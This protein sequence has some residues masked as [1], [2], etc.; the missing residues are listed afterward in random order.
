MDNKE[1]ISNKTALL[2]FVLIVLTLLLAIFL[3]WPKVKDLKQINTQVGALQGEKTALDSKIKAL[4]EAQS[5]IAAAKPSID[6]LNIAVPNNPAMPEILVSLES[7]VGRTGLVLNQLSPASTGEGVSSGEAKVTISVSGS[8]P[9][10]IRLLETFEKNIRPIKVNSLALTSSG[11]TGDTAAT[12]E[13]SLLFV[14]PQAT[15][16]TQPAG[17]EEELGA[18]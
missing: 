6:T 2:I 15:T 12:F 11:E 18:Q 3:A 7:I 9:N 14:P 1:V 4:E 13:L 17:S 8:Y 5:Q 16:S 10:V